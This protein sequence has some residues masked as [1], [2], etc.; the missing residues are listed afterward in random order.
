MFFFWPKTKFQAFG[1]LL[2]EIALSIHVCGEAID[3]SENFPYLGSV[4]LND[5]GTS[6]K[7]VQR[8]RLAHGVMDS[9]SMGIGPGYLVLYLWRQTKTR[10][11]KSLVIPVL[12][13]K[14]DT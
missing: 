5:G 13:Y 10:S 8:I 7:I 12:L 3:S 9:L 14:C 1:D 2:D 11:L 4:M 6:Q